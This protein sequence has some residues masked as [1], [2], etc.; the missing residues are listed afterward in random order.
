MP[1]L[2]PNYGKLEDPLEIM[3]RG[4]HVSLFLAIIGLYFICVNVLNVPKFPNCYLCYFGCASIGVAVS[5]LIMNITQYY[6]DYH[7]GPV[8]GIAE[9]S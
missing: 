7:Y 9:S 3:K 6:T 4:Y 2:K 1:S 5:W 8:Q